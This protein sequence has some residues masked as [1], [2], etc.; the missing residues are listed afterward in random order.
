MNKNPPSTWVEQLPVKLIELTVKAYFPFNNRNVMCI[1]DMITKLSAEI[2][3]SNI[4][5]VTT[6]Q[7]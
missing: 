2:L 3:G 4:E 1:M 7:S 6:K 5:C